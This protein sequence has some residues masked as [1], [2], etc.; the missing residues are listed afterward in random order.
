ML[1]IHLFAYKALVVSI[2]VESLLQTKL[3][4]TREDKLVRQME[5]CVG[6]TCDWWR[7]QRLCDWLVRVALNEANKQTLFFY[8]F[9]PGICSVQDT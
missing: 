3:N 9:A 6:F 1:F 8:S 5:N 2:M 4:V 7:Q